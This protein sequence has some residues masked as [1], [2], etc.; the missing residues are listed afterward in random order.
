MER[1]SLHCVP[2]SVA[3]HTNTPIRVPLLSAMETDTQM[4][5]S[6]GFDVQFS[7]ALCVIIRNVPQC[8]SVTICCTVSYCTV[9]AIM[10]C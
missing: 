3:M 6:L 9:C 2:L 8:V 4:F 7:T 5:M 1:H 10:F